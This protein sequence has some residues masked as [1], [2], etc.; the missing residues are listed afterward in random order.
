MSQT[1][2]LLRTVYSCRTVPYVVTQSRQR[3]IG[4]L[5]QFD[6]YMA[7]LHRPRADRGRPRNVNPP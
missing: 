2:T 6:L 5:G 4:V 7:T 1:V 3:N